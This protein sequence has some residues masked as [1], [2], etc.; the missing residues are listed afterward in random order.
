MVYVL[1]MSSNMF[2]HWIYLLNFCSTVLLTF[3][4]PACYY[5][6]IRSSRGF[7]LLISIRYNIVWLT[8][9]TMSH[10]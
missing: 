2:L 5:D 3:Q 10:V 4:K 6:S 7:N 8:K 1:K 9:L